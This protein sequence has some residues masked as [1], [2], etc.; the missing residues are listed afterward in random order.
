MIA[1]FVNTGTVIFGSLLGLLFRKGI[2]EKILNALLSAIGL[3]TVAIGIAGLSELDNPLLLILS[4]AIGSVIGALLDPEGWLE[5]LS[6]KVKSKNRHS[7]HR[8]T[9]G[10]VTA[11]L[12]FCVGSMTLTGSLNAGLSGD[13]TLI[14][15]KSILDLCSSCVLAASLGIG[16]L[17]SAGCLFCIQGALTLLAGL[18]A[19][20]L[21]ECAGALSACGAVLTVAIG[22]NL[23]GVTKFKVANMLPSLFLVPLLFRLFQLFV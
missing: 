18:L 4:L 5:K 2:P 17:F 9:E 22:L 12:L 11:T 16:V 8:I 1:V 21:T 6:Q 7:D 10:I 3:A 15:T 20:F 14:F 13:Y 19:P 23:I